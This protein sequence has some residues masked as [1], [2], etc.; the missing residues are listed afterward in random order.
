M[1]LTLLKS[2]KTWKKGLDFAL[3]YPQLAK[4]QVCYVVS[5][6]TAIYCL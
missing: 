1:T 4:D 3:T 5:K 2:N 6:I